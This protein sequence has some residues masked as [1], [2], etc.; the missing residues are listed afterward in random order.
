M[1]IYKKHGSE[2]Y[3]VLSDGKLLCSGVKQ[4]KK[5]YKKCDKPPGHRRLCEVC[6]QKN[7]MFGSPIPTKKVGGILSYNF[8]KSHEWK[9]L[10]YKALKIYGARCMVCGVTPSMGAVMNV[11]HIKPRKTHPHLALCL[12]NLQIVCGSCNEGKGNWDSTDW[13]DMQE[14]LEHCLAKY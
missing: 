1:Y 12:D 5:K 6:A 10:R 13:R 8:L 7:K 4:G 11:D 3:H 9:V 14:R 2:V